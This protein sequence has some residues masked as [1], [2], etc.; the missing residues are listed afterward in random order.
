MAGELYVRHENNSPKDGELNGRHGN[1]SPQGIDD[2]KITRQRDK[3]KGQL[4]VGRKITRPGDGRQKITL[5]ND[6]RRESYMVG[7]KKLTKGW[8]IKWSARKYLAQGMDDT[9]ITRQRD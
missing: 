8:R 1:N 7:T 6:R 5:Q 4:K 2:T 9:K 3:R